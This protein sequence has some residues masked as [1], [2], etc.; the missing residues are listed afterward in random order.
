MD[1][2]TG[3]CD[4]DH[5]VF[6]VNIKMAKLYKILHEM[7]RINEQSRKTITKLLGNKAG[8]KGRTWMQ[9]LQTPG[10][11]INKNS[12]FDV[13]HMDGNGFYQASFQQRPESDLM[14]MEASSYIGVQ[15]LTRDKIRQVLD[16]YFRY[17]K[18][19]FSDSPNILH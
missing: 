9:I 10:N 6:Q 7:N 16:N 13:A 17:A 18:E 3:E 11:M 1:A 12:D 2:Q 8:A 14:V 19:Q 15:E 4:D 5:I